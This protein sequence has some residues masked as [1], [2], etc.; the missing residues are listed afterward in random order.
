MQ[1]CGK[2]HHANGLCKAHD[3]R[4]RR[5]GKVEK[6]AQK[7]E[8][9]CLVE[10]EGCGKRHFGHGLC[11]LH[12]RRKRETGKLI[13]RAKKPNGAGCIV[14]S[15][16]VMLY[17]PDH[18]NANAQGSV[19]EHVVIMSRMLAR[20][21]VEG[22]SVHHKNGERADNRPENLELWTRAQ[23]AGQRVKDRIA[24][25]LEFLKF[26]A[27]TPDVW[28]DGVDTQGFLNALAAESTGYNQPPRR[29]PEPSP[30]SPQQ[31][32]KAEPARRLCQVESCGRKHYGRGLCKLHY[33]RKR[34]TGKLTAKPKRAEGTGRINSDGYVSVVCPDHPR[35]GTQGYVLEHILVMGQMLGRHLVEG[36]TVHHKNG[37]RTDNRPE[38]LE[39][40]A[41]SH[42]SGQRV[43]DRI[44]FYIDF[45]SMHA[46][47]PGVWPVRTDPWAVA[48]ALGQ[49]ISSNRPVQVSAMSARTSRKCKFRICEING[50]E[51]K[52]CAKG[53]CRMHYYQRG[54]LR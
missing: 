48:R 35:A 37:D 23:P 21:L 14:P 30:S 3:E 28:R 16:Y 25:Y 53:F 24:Y 40:W 33:V 46:W 36:E 11:M 1:G 29:T 17:R 10:V 49:T 34:L 45:L 38:N 19:S 39:L 43:K 5:T 52:H 44:A 9:L 13:A 4:K 47:T 15:G 20:P 32:E 50:C 54:T 8:R 41:T 18:P 51:R 26:H 12:Y 7:S 31:S 2:K 22:E 27:G 6:P 42:R